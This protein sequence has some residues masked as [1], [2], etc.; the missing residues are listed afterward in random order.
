M[1][2]PL[3]KQRIREHFQ[4]LHS[5]ADLKAWFDPLHFRVPETGI[6][7]V[8]FPH[9]LFSGWFGKERQNW[10]EKELALLLGP[11]SHI[12]FTKPDTARKPVA[13]K[14]HLPMTEAGQRSAHEL[15]GENARYSFEAFEYNR[16]NEFPVTMARELAS[17][18][19]DA[20]YVPFVICG[21]GSCGK[22]HL[23]RAMAG[24]MATRL[25]SGGIYC[26]A[27]EEAENLRKENPASFK[28]KMLRH[29]AIF[30]DNGQNLALYPD[31]QQELV[32]ITEKFK[33]KKKP[34]VVALDD[35]LDQQAI[36]PK[37]RAR[38]ESG[39]S[40]TLGKPD[41]D[42]RLRYAK[43]QCAAHG[44]HLKKELLLSIAQRFHTLTTI[45]GVILKAL[46]FQHNTERSLTE[47]DMEKLLAGTDAL[48]GRRPTAQAIINQVAEKFSLSPER[49]AGNDRQTKTVR[50]RQVAMYLCR[51]LLGT[52]YAS[53]GAY[54]NGK[55]HA[56]IIHAHRKIGKLVKSDKDMNKLVTTIRKK[57]LTPSG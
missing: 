18:M 56:T 2:T 20:A 39:L 43:A 6:L 7:E 33:E 9:A 24:L 22:T 50:A 37:L 47:A 21:G 44:F 25:P 48:T 34:F 19:T 40:V 36:N 29:K 23:L 42:I 15:L 32:F 28:R 38:L 55:N 31:L 51:E 27:V 54:F 1:E 4:T 46:A 5:D 49:L 52:P 8:C 30:L 11:A 13:A 35:S 3:D 10:F 41:L 12:V 45:Q 17:S 16:K 53:L 26:A 14:K 57:F